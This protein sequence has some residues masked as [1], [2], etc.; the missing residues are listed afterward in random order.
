[1][2]IL[3]IIASNDW[4][5]PIYFSIGMGPENYLGLEKYFQL[6]G[7]AY[8]LVPIESE[9]SYGE[10]GR[11]NS[12]LLYNNLMN[13]FEYGRIKE[14]DVYMDQFHIITCGIMSFR[15]NHVR[16]AAKLNDENK[17]EKAIKV[18]NKCM[19][20]LPTSKLPI[21]YALVGFIQEYYR[22]GEVEK[23][24]KLL[25][26]IAE[27][28]YEKMDYFLSLEPVYY[29]SIEAEQQRELR[30]VQML[31]GLAESGGQDELKTKIQRD[32]ES[33]FE[34]FKRNGG[35]NR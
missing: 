16:L 30:I 15:S 14:P 32:F 10:Y 6:E 23:A 25:E 13:K 8:R 3:D 7:A 18:L 27:N 24:N 21:D 31:L 4:D 11:I 1:M 19:E 9:N 22:A 2:M 34:T 35:N 20:E 5:R 29:S 12:D 17:P 28:S 33:L 26:Q